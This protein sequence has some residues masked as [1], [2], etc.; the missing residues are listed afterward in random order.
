[1]IT[2]GWRP[3]A[4]SAGARA[5]RSGPHLPGRFARRGCPPRRVAER[6]G[7][8]VMPDAAPASRHR[9]FRMRKF[10]ALTPIVPFSFGRRARPDRRG[11]GTAA[12]RPST[13]VA[14]QRSWD[15]IL[16][17]LAAPRCP[18]LSPAPGPWT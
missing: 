14:V 2:L 9:I 11:T 13:P 10:R 16:R 5:V 6:D 15:F 1:M 7:F 12:G 8:R 18:W 4:G 17:C 3:R